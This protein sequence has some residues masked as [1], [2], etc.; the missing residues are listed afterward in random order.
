MPGIRDEIRSQP[1]VIRKTIQSIR[2]ALPSIAP[3]AAELKNGRQVIITGMG[4]SFAAGTLLQFG[5][6]ESEI[7]SSVIE[8]SELLYHQHLLLNNNPLIVMI[9]QSGESR[10]VV[11]LLDE[12]EVRHIPCTIIGVT[13]TANS[14][15]SR[16][17][18]YTLLMQAGEEKT[19]STKTY[20]CTLTA[21]V[22]LMTALNGSD[23]NA[24]AH[25]LEQ[26]A[27]AIESALPGWETQAKRIADRIAKT[28]FMECLGRGESRAS[29]LTAAL[30]TKETA[31]LPTEGMVGG[32]FRHGPFEVLSPEISVLMFMGISGERTLDQ[33]LGADIEAR[34]ATVI[35]IGSDVRDDLGFNLP[36]LD[37]F[38][39]P[40]AEIIPVQ[41]LAVELA[42]RRGF[43][44]GEFRFITKVTTSE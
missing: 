39:T 24:A 17:S 44:P 36:A 23:Q 19:V 13:N 18:T 42:A 31:K 20:T 27:Q 22:L 8:S 37:P 25:A 41:L 21:L 28:T 15:L 30:I 7:P 2:A 34:G 6:G 3:Y 29:A 1:E 12:L 43:V 4:G 38:L 40:I 32:Q 10:E 35:R 26:T 9:S 33:A 5:L 14:T 11:R 16:R